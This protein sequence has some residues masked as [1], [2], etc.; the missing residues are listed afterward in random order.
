[1][2]IASIPGV[3]DVTWVRGARA[4]ADA[5]ADL[6]L[7]VAHG[8][9]RAADFDALAAEL[10]GPFPP[11]LRAF[12]FVNTDVG[13]PET[14]LRT[15]ERWVASAPA[16]TALVVRCRLPRTFVDCNRVI[17]PDTA[18]QASAAGAMTPGLP[19]WV[20]DAADLA[21]LRARYAAYRGLATAAV[22]DVCGRGGTAL[23]VHS[24]APRSVDVPVDE[25]VVE[26]LREA[27][28]PENLARWPL[29]AEVD[30]IADDPDGRPLAAE[31]LVA[32]VRSALVRV[33]LGVAR[34][35]AY[36]LHPSTLA[37]RFASR[38]PERTLCLEVRRDLLVPVFAGF[39]EMTVDAAKVERVAGA[40][41]EALAP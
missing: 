25:R 20:R 27:Y 35:Q 2:A 32:R 7:E 4:R 38:F 31:A 19:P 28:R 8:A 40:L 16:K 23:F 29:R 12:F 9:T 41:A 21:L 30:L 6:L 11:D 24:Y 13:A 17:E 18:P 33:G 36:T 3:A 1:M 39:S 37:H 5:P 34:S 10:R 15:A 22:E 26:R 14:A